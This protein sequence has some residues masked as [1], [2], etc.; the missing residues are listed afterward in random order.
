L[1]RKIGA[2][3]GRDE[4]DA[5]ARTGRFGHVGLPE[6]A[7]LLA[8]VLGLPRERELCEKLRPVIAQDEVRTPYLT[9]A[10]GRV[11]GIDQSTRVTVGGEERL[12]L[13][14]RM[15]VGATDAR[16]AIS[17]TGTP[18]LEMTLAGG[19]QGDVGTAA[20]TVHAALA[21][22]ELAPGLRTMLDVPLRYRP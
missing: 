14:L 11:A 12:S 4:F 10:P 21:T 15:Y 17:V 13:H 7:H 20:V 1:Q 8:D 3:L 16:D 5:L 19:V 18:P 9:V 22:R 6:S 2:G